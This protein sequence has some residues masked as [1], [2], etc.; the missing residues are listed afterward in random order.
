M[1]KGKKKDEEPEAG[2]GQAD[3]DGKTELD[4]VQAMVVEKDAVLEVGGGRP[5]LETV[6]RKEMEGSDA[7][8]STTGGGDLEKV[9]SDV[10]R[11][12]LP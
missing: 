6:E 10:V 7:S 5:E 12:E 8:P 1:A 4:A 3:L 9:Q 11:Y 2:G